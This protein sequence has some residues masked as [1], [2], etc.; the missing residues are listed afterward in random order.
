MEAEITFG[1]KEMTNNWKTTLGFAKIAAFLTVVCVVLLAVLPSHYSHVNGRTV[2]ECPPIPA[3]YVGLLAILFLVVTC[4]MAIAAIIESA[5]SRHRT[6]VTD[7]ND[8]VAEPP[9]GGD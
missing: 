9:A 5:M 7:E 1:Q 4:C 2:W 8:H 3:V 6:T